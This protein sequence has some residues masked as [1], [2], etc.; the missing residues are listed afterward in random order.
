MVNARSARPFAKGCRFGR[1]EERQFAG[2][3][4]PDDDGYRLFEADI[5]PVRDLRLIGLCEPA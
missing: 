1:I 2:A 4:L 3:I 5:E